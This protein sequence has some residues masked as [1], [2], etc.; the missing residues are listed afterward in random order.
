[1]PAHN[2]LN[3]LIIASPTVHLVAMEVFLSAPTPA[4]SS[5]EKEKKKKPTQLVAVDFVIMTEEFIHRS[6]SSA[7]IV[8]SCC[9][10]VTVAHLRKINRSFSLI[11]GKLTGP[12]EIL[13]R[14]DV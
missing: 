7:S 11:G 5:R 8:L 3:I 14:R 4:H 10:A 9:S 12:G 1:M 2:V 13:H 6:S